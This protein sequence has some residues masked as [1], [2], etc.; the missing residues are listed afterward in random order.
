LKHRIG[1]DLGRK[2]AVEEGIAWAARNDVRVVDIEIDCEPNALQSFL[3]S[4]GDAL[5]E[6]CAR[7]GIKLGLHTLS[8]VNVAELSPFVSEAVD[9]YLRA[10]VAAARRLGAGW[11]VVHARLPLHRRLQAA[12]AGGAGT[13]ETGRSPRRRAGRHAAA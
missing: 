9:Q 13:A 1:I 2:H 3:G 7:N 11:V 6:T 10:Y 8:A 5:R 12:P 4:R